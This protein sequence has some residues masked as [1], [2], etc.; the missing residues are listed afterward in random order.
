MLW[1]AMLVVYVVWGSTYLAIRV[2]VR[3]MPPLLSAGA[4]FMI[5]GLV[6]A[7]VLAVRDGPRE[8]RVSRRELASCA[9]LGLLLLLGGNGVVV[10]AER[11]VPSGYAALLVAAVPLWVV[12]LRAARA[13]RPRTATIAGVVIGFVGLVVL[14]SP[15]GSGVHLGGALTVLAASLS[16]A[17]G[18]FYSSRLPVPGNPFVASTYEMLVGGAG[19]ALVG[20]WHGEGHHLRFAA[21]SGA[22]W[23][24]LGYLVVFGSLVA[25]TAYV[26]L[27]GAAPISLVATYAY[28]NP[29]VAVALGALLLGERVTTAVLAGGAIVVLGVC[30]VV[31]TERRSRQARAIAPEPAEPAGGTGRAD[32]PARPAADSDSATR[33]G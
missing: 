26:W 16:W 19:N 32:Q 24:A 22:S 29:V 5:A 20:L 21:I 6:L 4:R 7:A 2:S 1:T 27:L 12:L 23:L 14:V 30:V 8:L 18:S 25:F 10:L 31:S 28:V 9:L 11:T 17:V 3:T 33:S 15:G 13:D